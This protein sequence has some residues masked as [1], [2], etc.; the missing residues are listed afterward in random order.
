VFVGA[1]GTLAGT[2][3]VAKTFID[4][5]G[6]LVAGHNA[7]PFGALTV[8]GDLVFTAAATYMVQVSP[9]DAGKTN[10]TGLATLGGATVQAVFAPGTYVTRQSTILHADGGLDG[11]FG[12]LIKTNLS[13]FLAASLSYPRCLAQ[14]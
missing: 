13:P 4:D 9:S 8:L 3:R 6:T 5:G 14:L 2:G 10:V 12:T 7:A 1:G 11:Q